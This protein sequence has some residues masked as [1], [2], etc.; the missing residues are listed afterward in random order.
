MYLC[1]FKITGKK[2]VIEEFH[3]KL[4]KSCCHPG[5][6]ALKTVW[7]IYLQVAA[8]FWQEEN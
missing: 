3:K 6:K 8:V 1:A 2:C 7:D 4:P 5:D